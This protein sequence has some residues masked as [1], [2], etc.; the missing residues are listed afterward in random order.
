MHHALRLLNT[1]YISWNDLFDN[2]LE[3][4]HFEHLELRQLAQIMQDV[5]ISNPARHIASGYLQNSYYDTLSQ[6]ISRPEQV[7]PFFTEHSEF[8][9][10]ALGLAPNQSD[11][12]WVYFQPSYAIELLAKFPSVPKQYVAKLLELALGQNKKLRFEAQEL[13]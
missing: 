4:K 11:S 12:R 5:G 7:V 6:Y 2:Y 13:L 3:P 1:R 8:I 9:T 10:E